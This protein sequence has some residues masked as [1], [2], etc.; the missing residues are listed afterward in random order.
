MTAAE[1]P[2]YYQLQAIN[3]TVEAVSAGQNRLFW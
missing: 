1:N 2:R 3:K